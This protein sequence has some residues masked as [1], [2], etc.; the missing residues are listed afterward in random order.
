[1]SNVE[2]RYLYRDGGNYKKFGNVVF[3]N[4]EEI[5]SSAIEEALTQVV[6]KDGLFIAD[7]VRVPEVFLFA[8]GQLSLDD[9]C[10]HELGAVLTTDKDPTDLHARTISA[11]LSEVT[12]QAQRGWRVF[13]PYDSEGSIGHFLASQRL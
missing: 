8:N 12:Q 7:Q 3:S 2:F 13:D 6:L 9:H 4:P 10:Y 5:S 11:F 1:M